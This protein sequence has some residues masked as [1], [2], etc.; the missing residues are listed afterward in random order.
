MHQIGNNKYDIGFSKINAS[1]SKIF[2]RLFT[3]YNFEIKW[4]ALDHFASLTLYAEKKNL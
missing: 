4:D 2:Q 3:I 1:R